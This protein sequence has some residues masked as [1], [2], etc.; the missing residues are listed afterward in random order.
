VLLLQRL[1]NEFNNVV[2]LVKYGIVT[3]LQVVGNT[4]TNQASDSIDGSS[5]SPTTSVHIGPI[6]SM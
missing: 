6:A 1:R 2:I 4:I 3:G 5:P